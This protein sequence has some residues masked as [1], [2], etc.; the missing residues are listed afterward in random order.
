[1][2]KVL[3]LK[4]I[5]HESLGL[6]SDLL[7]EHHIEYTTIDL[8]KRVSFPSIRHYQLIII[9]GG[10]DSANDNSL[11]IQNEL[12]FVKSAME[13]KVPV[14]GVCL[15]L[16]LMVKACGGVVL[17]NPMQEIGFKNGSDWY[18]VKLTDKG[19]KDPIFN[20]VKD[21]FVVFQLHGETVQLAEK[22]VLLGT[23]EYCQNQVVRIGEKSYGLQFHFELTESLFNSW[24][25]QAPELKF[26]DIEV[27]KS[28]FEQ[29]KNDYLFRGQKI[30]ENYLDLCKLI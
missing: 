4:N 12:K 3:V 21:N 22:M 13:Q 27:L 15:G 28:Q 16:Q 23:G 2:V 7:E 8:S 1:M 10:P 5:E 17:K 6:M 19:L 30:F 26:Q 24:L 25:K 29:I 14:L 11:K 9:M 18:E 20:G